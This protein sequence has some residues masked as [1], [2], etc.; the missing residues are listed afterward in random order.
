MFAYVESIQNLKD[1]KDLSPRNDPTLR[2]PGSSVTNAGS[3]AITTLTRATNLLHNAQ[4]TLTIHENTPNQP[5]KQ[6][7]IDSYNKRRRRRQM[8]AREPQLRTDFTTT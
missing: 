5:T 7:T 2:T 3:L 1:L 6:I 8:E 4:R